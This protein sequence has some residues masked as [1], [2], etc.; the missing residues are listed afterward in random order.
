MMILVVVPIVVVMAFIPTFSSVLGLGYSEPCAPIVMVSV[1]CY[2]Q[3]Y[4]NSILPIV[5]CT[6]VEEHLY[7]LADKSL[8]II[9][10][11]IS[12]PI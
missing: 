4:N 9:G 8:T 5:R 11:H 10:K 2:R 12:S 6:T 7:Y 1:A 3:Y